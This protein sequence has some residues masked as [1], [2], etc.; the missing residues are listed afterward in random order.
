[1]A[2]QRADGIVREMVGL[3][4]RMSGLRARRH[5]LCVQRWRHHRQVEVALSSPDHSAPL[6]G[7]QCVAVGPDSTVEPC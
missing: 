7:Y 1:M 3:S 6:Y 4:V 2:D 5:A